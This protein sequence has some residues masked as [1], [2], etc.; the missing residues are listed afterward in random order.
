M[1][2]MYCLNIR[3]FFLLGVFCGLGSYVF[4]CMLFFVW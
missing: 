1:R 4:V 2:G 3:V